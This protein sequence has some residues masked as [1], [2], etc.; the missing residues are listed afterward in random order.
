MFMEQCS[1]SL[2]QGGGRP[3]GWPFGLLKA[4]LS[5][6]VQRGQ[7]WYAAQD[8]GEVPSRCMK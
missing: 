3:Y 5:A 8:E 4:P 6:R 1:W 7:T 2:S